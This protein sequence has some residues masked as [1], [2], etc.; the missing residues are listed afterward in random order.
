MY[1]TIRRTGQIATQCYNNSGLLG[2]H[3]QTILGSTNPQTVQEKSM[4][5][6][7]AYKYK[8]QAAKQFATDQGTGHTMQN[9]FS[10]NETDCNTKI[11]NQ[12]C[13][14]IVD[15]ETLGHY[16]HK[17][18]TNTT[19]EYLTSTDI[20]GKIKPQFF[21][22][23]SNKPNLTPDDLKNM[24]EDDMEINH[25]ANQYFNSAQSIIDK[26]TK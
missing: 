25:K 24:T 3:T 26:I 21:V 16:T 11:C 17:P 9:K 5:V 13:D 20:T 14:N 19:S 2:N 18:P 8:T 22:K 4:A 15:G 10:C 7:N 12:P 1:T 23:P 6:Y